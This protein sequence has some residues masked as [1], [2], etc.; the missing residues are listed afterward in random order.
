MTSCCVSVSLKP[1]GQVWLSD[2]GFMQI[3]ANSQHSQ[4]A[5]CVRHRFLIKSLGRHLR[6]REVQQRYYWQH[7]REQYLDRLEY[8]R[9]RA[10]SRQADGRYITIIQDGMDQGK[11]AIPRSPWL[12]SKEFAQFKIHRPKLHVS[13]TLVHGYFLLWTISH[14][15]TMK[16]SNASL[17]T[18]AHA[19]HLLETKHG[20]CLRGCSLS[21]HADNTAR[22]IKNNPFFKWAALQVSAGNIKNIS[23]RFLR[24]GHSH[25]DVDQ[26]FGRLSRH[27]AKLKTAQT[28]SDFADSTNRFA[29]DMYRPHESKR[30]VVTMPRTRDWNLGFL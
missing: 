18:M 17:E 1:I 9:L 3:R 16:D 22:E 29:A 25:E 27:Y 11:V 19:L 8:Y 30:Y 2:F 21:I 6:A 10:L 20:V 24:S 23:V 14:P 12:Q 7:L 28:P 15:E 4:C 26:C 13:L 5:T